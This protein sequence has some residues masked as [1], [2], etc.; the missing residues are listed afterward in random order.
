MCFEDV[1]MYFW[2]IYITDT[3]AAL[4]IT[5]IIPPKKNKSNNPINQSDRDMGTFHQAKST[6]EKENDNICGNTAWHKEVIYFL[7]ILSKS[8]YMVYVC[9]ELINYNPGL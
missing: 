3:K 4:K 5:S 1:K 9:G 6:L 8:D 2:Y 7:L